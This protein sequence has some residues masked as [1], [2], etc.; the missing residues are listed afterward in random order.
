MT[1]KRERWYQH[2]PAVTAVVPCEGE[3]HHVTWRWGKYKLD[4]HD[5]G[6]ERAMLTLG[7]D[8][9]A[10]VRALGLWA[11][12]FGMNPEYYGEMRRRMGAEAVLLPKEFDVP[13]EVGMALSVERA[14]KKSLYFD[15]QGQ[16]L[17]RQLKDLATPVVRAHLNAEKQRIGSRVIRGVKI[18]LVPAGRALSIR[19]RMDSVS[20]TADVTLS[21]AWVVHV[22]ARGIGVVDGALV[23]TVQGPGSTP[24]AVAVKAARWEQSEPGV[25]E[26][27]IVAAEVVPTG[28]DGDDDADDAR[29]H[30]RLDQ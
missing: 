7:G 5:I 11:N 29:W 2:V 26:P 30:L 9:P 21:S 14:W 27:R 12:L 1:F 17:E 8:P 20:V 25:S 10:C 22:W 3:E 23:M 28:D 19:G 16:L 4:D 6:S 15:R 13:R 18:N 24:G